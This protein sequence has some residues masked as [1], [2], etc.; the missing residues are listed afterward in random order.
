MVKF[1]AV[2]ESKIRLRL[3]LVLLQVVWAGK[4]FCLYKF[5]RGRATLVVVNIVENLRASGHHKSGIKLKDNI[6]PCGGQQF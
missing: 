1:S 4:C 5:E 2:V 6:V 3:E